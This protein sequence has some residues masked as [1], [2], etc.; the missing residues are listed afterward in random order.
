VMHEPI[1]VLMYHSVA[2]EI[3]GWAFKYL[4]LDP[5]V[6]ED[7]VAAMAR[8]GYTSI[9]LADLYAYVGKG[10][11]LPPRSIVLTFDDGYLDNWVYA[12]PVL[13]KYGFKATV[14]VS[15]DFIDARGEIRPT[16][17]DVW[18]GRLKAG[19]LTR[20]GFLSIPEMKRM[21]ESGLVDI[22]G[23]CK[24]HTWHFTG[25][26]IV[27]FHRPGAPRPW[28]A[29]N[30][31]PDRKPLYLEEDQTELVPF[32]CPVY[33]YEKSLVAR[34]WLPNAV[35]EREVAE[36]VATQGGSAFFDRPDW[37][38]D[39]IAKARA[40]TA[41]HPAGRY[42]TEVEREARLWDEIVGSKLELEAS[43]AKKIDFLCWPGGG[44][45]PEAVAL[46]KKAGYLAWTL[47]SK[48]VTGQKNLPGEDPAWIRRIAAAPWW[49]FRGRRTSL[50]DGKFM[51]L[52]LDEYKDAAFSALRLK[53]Y[54]LG[55]LILSLVR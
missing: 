6:F 36:H 52:I 48:A 21:L 5:A 26:E 18:S 22:Q 25:E 7:Q 54:K 40:I 47:G 34:R 50:V 9:H 12:Y 38:Q 44:Y 10:R 53:C 8:S 37:N 11:S 29:W 55:R 2:P 39:L 3:P 19:C 4:S 13:K 14:F 49:Y 31:R 17:E 35:I 20:A 24:T 46:A 30:A 27:D 16:L 51:Q 42:E 41:A 32:G 43:L 23:H 45:G 28:L 33:V 1:P 15:T